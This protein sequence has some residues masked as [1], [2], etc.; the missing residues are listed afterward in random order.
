M[1]STFAIHTR[2]DAMTISSSDTIAG[3]IWVT[4]DGRAFPELGWF[5]MPV[6]VLMRWLAH[7]KNDKPPF[8]CPFFDGP[9]SLRVSSPDQHTYEIVP[10]GVHGFAPNSLRVAKL[11]FQNAL[12]V[13]VSAAL[14][15]ATT[16]GWAT[17]D[18]ELLA[19][20]AHSYFW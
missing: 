9:Y 10:T 20:L 16:A 18:T 17:R 5:D 8:T 4:I 14:N 2:P 15:K 6:V 1:S 12:E 13:A 19:E 11:D 7:L 3:P